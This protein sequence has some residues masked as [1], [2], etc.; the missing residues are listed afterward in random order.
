VSEPLHAVGVLIEAVKAVEHWSDLELAERARVRGFEVSR[1]NLNRIRR[2]PPESVS[3]NQIRMLSAALNVPELRVASAYFEALG[4]PIQ[5]STRGG[6]VEAISEA[7]ALNSDD[8]ELL[9]VLYRTML[10]QR[11][12]SDSTKVQDDTADGQGSSSTDVSSGTTTGP[13]AQTTTPRGTYVYQSD[14]G[15][16]TATDPGDNDAVEQQTVDREV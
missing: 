15:D 3:L 11:K 7:G 9:I 14:P 13:E 5:A 1:S 16:T 12:R 2:R 4:F 8:R 6:V 10:K